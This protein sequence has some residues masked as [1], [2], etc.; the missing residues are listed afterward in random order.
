M[1]KNAHYV[2]LLIITLCLG[3]TGTLTAQAKIPKTLKPVILGN[4][5]LC[6]NSGSTLHT[7]K[8][9][10]TYQWYVRDYF[11]DEKILI[12][13]AI[14]NELTVTKDDVLKYFSVEVTLKGFK[15]SSEEKLIDGLVFIP[16]TVMSGGDFKNGP[17]FFVLN[18]GDTGLFTLLQPYNT[19][20]T[21]YRNNE[22]ITGATLIE[23]PVTQPGTYTVKGAPEVCP[24]YI[25]YLGVDLIVKVKK[26]NKIPI[27][28]GDTMLCPNEQGMLSTQE[29]YSSYK[30]YKR[31][32]GS[33]DKV[34]IEGATSNSI[35]INAYDDAPAYFSV[36]VVSNGN[37]L[38]S[39]EKLVDSYAFLPP[40][41][42]SDGDF[43]NGP[44]YFLLNQ[45]DTGTFTLT[46]PYETSI[47][48]YRNNAAIEGE[49]ST[50]LNVTKG[51][52]YAVQA[53]PAVCPDFVQ[54]LGVDLIVKMGNNA[55]TDKS[56]A[57]VKESNGNRVK[58][59][60]NPAKDFVTF[61]ATA[62]AG[63]DIDV[64]LSSRD[65]KTV[66]TKNFKKV[67]GSVKL[68]LAGIKSGVYYI[69]ISDKQ[70]QQVARLVVTK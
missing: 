2:S 29:G 62:F 47:T 64:S 44:G 40:A 36:E 8:I 53:A 68:E 38:I 34:V 65:G 66:F 30:W 56:S 63:K 54:N 33:N 27:V 23:L 6:P 46:Q 21:W 51:G 1:R 24:D 16:P 61:D 48:W 55:A 20:I 59:Y 52:N 58:L 17:G 35:K 3:V 11:S 18:E 13:G 9:Y 12:P 7:Q 28:S 69:R 50:T 31:F 32:Y 70:Q 42:I 41:V 49:K 57:I 5:L 10:D 15:R 22:P 25:Q 67:S 37:T 43:I 19:N 60:P 4:T 14:T 26:N 39:A 45:G